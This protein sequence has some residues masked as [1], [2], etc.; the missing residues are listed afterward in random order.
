MMSFAFKVNQVSRLHLLGL[1]C[2]PHELTLGS[3]KFVQVLIP[4]EVSL[5]AT[6]WTPHKVY[7]YMAI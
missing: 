4:M 7:T 6:S 3:S 1:Q 5:G 2:V